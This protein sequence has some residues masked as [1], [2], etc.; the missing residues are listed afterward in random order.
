MT[1][2]FRKSAIQKLLQQERKAKPHT[3]LLVD[4]EDHN[5]TTLSDLLMD[6]YNILTATDG[7]EALQVLQEG[8]NASQVQLIISDQRMPR[9]SGVEF[10]KRSLSVAPKAKRIILTGY[11]DVK[12][13]IESINDAQIYKFIHKPFD[14]RDM[15]LT[16]RLALEAYDLEQQNQKLLHDLRELNRN[17]ENKVAERTQELRELNAAKDRFFSI[18]AHDLRGPLNVFVLCTDMLMESSDALTNPTVQRLAGN[19]QGSALILRRL[20]SNL[21]DWSS[22]Q[23]GQMRCHPKR[24]R[25]SRIVSEV[26]QLVEDNSRQKEQTLY[27]DVPD[28]L[29]ADLDSNF[30][31][32]ILRN[33]LN[34]AIKFTPKGGRIELTARALDV[35]GQCHLEVTVRDEGIGIQNEDLDKLF[36]IDTRHTTRGTDGEQGTGLGLT[37]CKS[38]AIEHGGDLT[39]ESVWGQGTSFRLQLPCNAQEVLTRR[40]AYLV[41]PTPTTPV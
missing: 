7:D 2:I 33:L 38:M 40:N 5:L 19:L 28:D 15:L 4:D 21:Q 13:I 34:N 24:Q 27:I 3:I 35:E 25:L 16:V 10:L 22:L 17:L 39:V 11:T 32:T 37:L 30:I 29:E 14:H 9:M 31:D 26:H 20:L 41:E 1:S 12:A 23:M 36:R 18:I 6:D 8:D